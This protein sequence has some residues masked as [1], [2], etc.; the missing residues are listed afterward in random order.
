[1]TLL[2]N[3]NENMFDVIL[4]I[5][6][7]LITIFTVVYS[8]IENINQKIVS[9]D[10][11]IKALSKKDPVKESILNFSLKRKS[12]LS[13][14]NNLIILL[15]I[16]DLLI[17]GL[18]ILT[19]VCNLKVLDLVYKLA[20]LIFVTSCVISLLFYIV[21]YIQRMKIFS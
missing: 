19:L 21:K 4:S 7:I 11:D 1:M 14:Y 13:K 16:S 17:I 20:S 8:F 9:L 6:G 12:Q 15:M 10:N 3:F 2:S 18:Y 5:L